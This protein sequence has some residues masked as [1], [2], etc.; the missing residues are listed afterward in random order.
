LIP[1]LVARLPIVATL[2]ALNE[3]SL[4]LVL[5]QT[6]NS[7][8]RQY[9]RLFEIEAVDLTLQDDALTTIACKAVEDETGAWGLRAIMENIL[10]DVMYHLPSLK[11]VVEVVISREVVEG[12]AA[13]V[14]V[15][16]DGKSDVVK[17]HFTS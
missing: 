14:Y 2:E 11:G 16:A 8:L 10:L 17:E 5:T 7:L 4:K 12:T 3:A 9:Q 1:E 6:K 13:P 15:Y